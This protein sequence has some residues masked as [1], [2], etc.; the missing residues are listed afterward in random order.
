MRFL[1]YPVLLG[2]LLWASACA[3]ALPE[4]ATPSAPPL[5]A[6]TVDIDTPQTGSIFYAEV[7]YLAGSAANL[8]PEGFRLRL[9]TADDTRLAETMVQP[10]DDGR[11]SLELRHGYSGDPI[12]VSIL[13]LPVAA[14]SP[15]EYALESVVISALANRPAGT[16]GRLLSPTAETRVGGDQIQVVGTASGVVDGTLS[17]QL[18]T[19]EGTLLT[20]ET[21][22]L[23]HPYPV[24]EILW[25]TDLPIGSYRGAARLVLLAQDAAGERRVLDEIALT[26]G[27]AAG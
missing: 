27:A 26:I 4:N 15:Q 13:A 18:Q 23:Q 14:Q 1:S 19:P 2:A 25:Q 11:W 8:P 3:P 10:D 5:A 6:G 24:D 20:E 7:L 21:V 16:F 12:E 22:H 9:V 17:V